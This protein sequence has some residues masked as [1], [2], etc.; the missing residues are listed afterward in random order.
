METFP[1][2]RANLKGFIPFDRNNHMD[3][4]MAIRGKITVEPS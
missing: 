4:T 2:R 3:W 1:I